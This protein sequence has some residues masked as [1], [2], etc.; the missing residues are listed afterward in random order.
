MSVTPVPS[1]L[2]HTRHTYK[3]HVQAT[4]IKHAYKAHLERAS[5]RKEAGS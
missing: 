3:A 2:P 4:H 5:D 1:K